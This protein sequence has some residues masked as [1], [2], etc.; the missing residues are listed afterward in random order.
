MPPSMPVAR[1]NTTGNRA[2][3][4]VRDRAIALLPEAAPA[5]PP[6][7]FGSIADRRPRRQPYASGRTPAGKR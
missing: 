5:L 6:R 2:L 3:V 4:A 1:L 7:G